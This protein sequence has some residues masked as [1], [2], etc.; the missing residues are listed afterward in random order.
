M[1]RCSVADARWLDVESAAR[2][3]VGHF[4]NAVAI[5][6]EGGFNAPGLAGYKAAM[7]FMHAMQ[8]GHTSM[9]SALCRILDILGEE[10]PTGTAWHDDLIRRVRSERPGS[11][12]PILAP[13]A[14]DHADETS[15]KASEAKK[16]VVA[17]KALSRD[18]LAEV[19]R[20]KN[21]IDPPAVGGT[22][23]SVS[24]RKAR[25]R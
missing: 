17:A 21:A 19:E 3:A 18:L 12:P 13:G 9:E 6:G 14:A 5:F 25:G 15:F 24:K 23:A 10:R 2:E 16:T 1:R 4:K 8:S 11:R 22:P 20:F 7:A